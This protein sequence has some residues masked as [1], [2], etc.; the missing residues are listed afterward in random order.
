MSKNN[1]Y[2]LAEEDYTPKYSVSENGVGYM[3]SSEIAKTNSFK[4]QLKALLIIEK[5]D[6]E[7]RSKNK[8]EESTAP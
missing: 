6:K 7:K 4:K 1:D 5:K 3:P 8:K 2:V